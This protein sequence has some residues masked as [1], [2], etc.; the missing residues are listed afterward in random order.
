M[1]LTNRQFE[2]ILYLAEQIEEGDNF[3]ADLRMFTRLSRKLEQDIYD[4]VFDADVLRVLSRLQPIAG[5]EK[6]RTFWNTVM[7]KS[8]YGMYDRYKQKENFREQVRDT[9]TIF[10]RIQNML[11]PQ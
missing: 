9:A 11:F 2:E 4:Q 5:E 10:S 1:S 6:K 7:P 8:T 3:E